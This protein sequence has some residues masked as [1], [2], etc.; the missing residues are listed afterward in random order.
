[1]TD[2]AVL[3]AGFGVIPL[4]AIILYTVTTRVLAYREAAW[5][6]LA[7]VLGF[8][9]VSHAMAVVLV[10]HSLLG[11]L[12][13]ATVL[14]FVGLAIGAGIAWLLLDGPFI[15]TEPNKI[16]W[17]AVAFLALHSFGDGLVL[18]GDFTGAFLPTLRVD[19]VTV[20][21]TIAHRFAEGCLVVVP[22]I[23]AA[24]RPRPAFAVLFASLASIPAAYAPGWIFASFGFSPIPRALS[25]FLAGMEATV[26]LML[27]VRGFI[28]IA[29]ADRGTRWPVWIAIGF[30]AVSLVHFFVE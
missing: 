10:N 8:L 23:W 25:T 20:M 17:A 16:L 24:W 14:S 27:L 28:P 11:D 3:A 26:G 4:A 1:M 19:A 13:A 30:I 5:G 2:L 15:Q 12:V 6:F 9:G 29:A 7:G 22:A 21:A 18:G